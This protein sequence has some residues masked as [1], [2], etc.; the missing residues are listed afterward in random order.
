MPMCFAMVFFLS[1]TEIRRH[2]NLS[3]LA[4]NLSDGL[5]PGSRRDDVRTPAF[6]GETIRETF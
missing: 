1:W 3:S 5:V 2:Q 6:A 4:E